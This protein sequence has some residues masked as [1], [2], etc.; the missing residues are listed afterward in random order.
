VAAA[1]AAVFAG[2]QVQMA[3]RQSQH[4]ELQVLHELR[5]LWARVRPEWLGLLAIGGQFYVRP[6]AVAVER[7]PLL[8]DP[9]LRIYI[10]A[11][12][13]DKMDRQ[14]SAPELA[15][16]C[17]GDEPFGGGWPSEF[18]V[19][20]EAML[21][22]SGENRPVWP[23]AFYREPLGLLA[24]V[25]SY[26]LQ[27]RLSARLAYDVLGEDIVRN[28]AAVRYA[29]DVSPEVT[30]YLHYHPGIR[31]RVLILLDVLWAEAAGRGDLN[32]EEAQTARATK[33]VY[34]SGVR[35]RC[36]LRREARRFGSLTAADVLDWRLTSAEIDPHASAVRRIVSRLRVWAAG[37]WLPCTPG[38]FPEYDY[39]SRADRDLH[40]D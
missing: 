5:D 14:I 18:T 6:D 35:N 20:Q 3:R 10:E 4:I 11:A 16:P 33:R 37:R 2:S 27:G 15:D 7:Y 34:R 22:P 25:C 26:L 31:R 8:G 39:W 29:I 1:A 13:F 28:S 40:P 12:H 24:A 23:E 38:T 30:Y 21:D 36:R 9:G 17:E 19:E 32:G